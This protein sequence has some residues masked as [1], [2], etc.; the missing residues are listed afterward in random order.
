MRYS[1]RHHLLAAMAMAAAFILTGCAAQ[2]EASVRE[3]GPR[4]RINPR[5]HREHVMQ[6]A[7]RGRPYHSLLDKLGPPRAI[8]AHPGLRAER[9][10]IVLYG[11]RDPG[12]NCIDAFTVVAPGSSPDRIVADYF[13]R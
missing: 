10:E 13:C 4:Q 2:P 1:P 8:M 6:T 12:S 7:W 5:V 11:V 3:E 9:G